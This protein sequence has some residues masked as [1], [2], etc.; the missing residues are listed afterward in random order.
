VAK[1]K[2]KPIELLRQQLREFKRAGGVLPPAYG[3][4]QCYVCGGKTHARNLRYI[5]RGKDNECIY[6]HEACEA[7]SLSWF[8]N[9]P[10]SSVRKYFKD[11]DSS[12]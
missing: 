5:G 10:N 8:R 1:K 7:G 11:P 3:L 12:D 6:R 9:M 2:E 4:E